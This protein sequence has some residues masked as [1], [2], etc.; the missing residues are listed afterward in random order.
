MSRLFFIV[1]CWHR[2]LHL[3]QMPAAVGKTSTVETPR[4]QMDHWISAMTL[5]MQKR[6]A[7]DCTRQFLH[8]NKSD[9]GPASSSKATK[10]IRIDLIHLD[11]NIIFQRQCTR[12]HLRHHGGN[13]ASA[14][15][16]RGT[17]TLHCGVNSDF[18]TFH[19]RR[20]LA[21][22]LIFWQSTERCNKYTYRAHVFLIRTLSAC[23]TQLSVKVVLQVTVI[24]SRMGFT[25]TRGSSTT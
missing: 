16:Q 24:S 14:G 25:H 8:S 6:H 22:N 10:N 17:G 4:V 13:R 11:G 1:G 21:G 18:L 7:I 2:I 9:K 15:G 12:L 5:K 3:R 19:M 20:S 23:L